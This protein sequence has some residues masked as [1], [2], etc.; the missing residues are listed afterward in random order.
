GN[1]GVP[2]P[3]NWKVYFHDTPMSALNAYVNDAFNAES[4]CLSSF[5][6]S[7]YDPP[8]GTTF[9]D[10]VLADTLPTYA[11]IE[12]RYFDNHGGREGLPPNSNH[13]GG[14][15]YLGVTGPPIDVTN[16]ELLLADICLALF[17]NPEVY[18]KTLLI[19]TYDE[20]GGLYDHVP[21]NTAPF[22][23]KAVSPFVGE[24]P[25]NFDYTRF[26][27]RVPTFFVNR[28]I[29]REGVYRPPRPESGPYYPFDHTSIIATLC[30]QF[31][32]AGPLTPRDAAA[33][34]LS[35]LV[36]TAES[37]TFDPPPLEELSRWRASAVGDRKANPQ[38]PLSP[39]E[40]DRRLT[41]WVRA[42]AQPRTK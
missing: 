13:P 26:G 8:H 3:A 22:A 30:A 39:A 17:A 1:S 4:P 27:V 33:P 35:G 25:G 6:D 9:A 21:P 18:A 38:P 24:Q 19:V 23:P 32:L 14:S 10:D 31:G 36:T 12:P 11:F 2:D 16:G 40:H 29:A 15:D 20:H 28:R 37:E 34:I 42:K 7:D 5:D 41:A